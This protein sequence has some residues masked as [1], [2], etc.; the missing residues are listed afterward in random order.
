M[1]LKYFIGACFLVFAALLKYGV[2]IPALAAGI[3]L[4]A[5]FYWRQQRKVLPK[6]Q[7]KSPPLK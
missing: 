5:L 3:A 7:Q 4:A 1:K 2:P 6:A